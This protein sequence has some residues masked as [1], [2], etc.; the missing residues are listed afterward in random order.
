MKESLAVAIVTLAASL[1]V[2]AQIVQN[3]QTADNAALGTTVTSPPVSD[4][5]FH[6]IG[7]TANEKI[8]EK[9]TYE[10]GAYAPHVHRVVRAATGLHFQAQPDGPWLDSSP[11]ISIL[12]DNSGASA[13]QCQTAVFLAGDLYNDAMQVTGPDG[14]MMRCRPAV[15]A[16]SDG[17]R[18]ALIAQLKAGSTGMLLPSGTGVL[19]TNI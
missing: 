5:E 11:Q 10:P 4:T 8:L 12:A 3:A 1:S 2:S 6:E 19:Y 13:S 15:L 16:F 17:Q 7:R 14:T 18:S 9:L